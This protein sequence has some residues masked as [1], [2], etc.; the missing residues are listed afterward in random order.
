MTDIT[1]DIHLF[2]SIARIDASLSADRIALQRLPGE[3]AGI[4]KA[5]AGLDAAEKK[6]H[7]D[8]EEKKKQRR[9]V[10]KRLRE[11]EEHLK[12]IRGQTS[13]VKTN[14]EYTAMLKEVST[15]EATISDEEEQLLILMDAI[16]ESE[17]ETRGHADTL[18]AERAAKLAEKA[19]L[20]GEIKNLEGEA[21][22]LGVEKPKLLKEISPTLAKRYERLAA[23]RDMA[24]TRV[25]D[26]HCG[27]C[28]QQ[29]PPQ[30][31]V[32]VRKND[33]FIT[34][35]ACGRILVHYAD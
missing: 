34:C 32:E 26:E 30:L 33:Q 28:H 16:D 8:L 19:R 13:L 24:V 18:K 25:E 12:K 17:K 6:A 7:D 4:D 10:E 11:H 31:A 5:V 27:A 14:E 23:H 9:D 3:I 1:R 29:I 35:P 20:E 22:R 21:Q 15:L 2:V